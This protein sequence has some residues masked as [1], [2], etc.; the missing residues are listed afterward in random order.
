MTKGK[1]SFPLALASPGQPPPRTSCLIG[2]VECGR[3]GGG[4]VCK[5]RGGG[6][7]ISIWRIS[8]PVTKFSPAD[9]PPGHAHRV[10][11]CFTG[12]KHRMGGGG[13]DKANSMQDL[14][15]I[16]LIAP[17]IFGG[18]AFLQIA[19]LEVCQIITFD[20]GILCFLQSD[21]DLSYLFSSVCQIA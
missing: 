8:P 13:G 16:H 11:R 5:A 15:K 2:N 10:R 14:H 12:S 9:S 18:W 4:R 1:A 17:P 21:K 3:R 19:I 6:E 7:S 20:E